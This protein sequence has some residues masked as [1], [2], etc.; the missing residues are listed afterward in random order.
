MKL[1]T[2]SDEMGCDEFEYMEAEA[3]RGKEKSRET[4]EYCEACQA[5]D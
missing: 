2:T 5:H 4:N 1:I 3:A